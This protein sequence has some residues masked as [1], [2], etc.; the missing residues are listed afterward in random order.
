MKQA[1]L[2]T[3]IEIDKKALG[4]NIKTVKNLLPKGTGIIF[5][6]KANA[7]GH[8]AVDIAKAAEQNGIKHFAVISVD[9]G[10]ELRKAG[11]AGNILIL[12]SAFPYENLKTACQ[13][14]LIP[15]LSSLSDIKA[16][17]KLASSLHKTLSFHLAVDTGMGRLGLFS[18]DF[19][20]LINS[21][22]QAKNIKM[23]GLYSHFASAG[24]DKTFTKQQLE[25]FETLI[26][27]AKQKISGFDIHMA[28][29]SALLTLKASCFDFVR[30]GICLYGINP[31]KNSLK[32]AALKPVLSWKTK[33]VFIKSVQKGQP[34]SYGSTFITKKP[35]T[36][37][38]L[39]IG[40]SDGY[41][42]SFSNKAQVLIKG[43][44]CPVVG[45]V[46]MNLTMIDISKVSSAKL[47]DEAVLIGRQGKKSVL[48]TDLAK[49]EGTIPYEIL[50]SISSKIKRI[51]V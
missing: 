34:I 24:Q 12:G 35:S 47:G 18:A 20:T 4:S 45:R 29:S 16:F 42:T 28:N 50:C 21:I 40:Y 8:G 5:V 36:I 2:N 39:P 22:A 14:D 37:A 46:T 30:S 31:L 9:E 11:I 19:P 48:S 10:L 6:V 1:N 15:S 33:I 49:I 43:E 27:Y 26:D 25:R 51:P 17:Q 32:V 3:W 13:N 41:S 23:A 38:V 7:Y 44:L